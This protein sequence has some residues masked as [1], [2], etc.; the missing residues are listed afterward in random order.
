ML[1][2]NLL[3]KIFIFANSTFTENNRT[4][5]AQIGCVEY[6]SWLYKTITR[7]GYIDTSPKVN[8]LN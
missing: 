1:E 8:I 5:R 3:S 6:K 2:N 7:D 4:A